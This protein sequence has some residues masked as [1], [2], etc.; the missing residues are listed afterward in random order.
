M[1][2]N[3]SNLTLE[4][5]VID[6][7]NAPCQNVTSFNCGVVNIIGNTSILGNARAFDM[8]W[9]PSEAYKDGTQITIDTTGTIKGTIYLDFYGA[10]DE[11][12]KSTLN[13]KNL[14]HEGTFEIQETY[15]GNPVYDLLVNQLTIEGGTYST[16]VSEYLGEEY[17][18]VKV[19]DSEYEVVTKQEV[20]KVEVPTVEVGENQVGVTVSEAASDTLK[21]IAASN[22]EVKKAIEEGKNV[23]VDIVVEP[24]A[25][26]MVVEEDKNLITT[27]EKDETPKT[28]VAS[29]VAIIASVLAIA[30]VSLVVVKTRKDIYKK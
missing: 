6:G 1:I 24:L 19:S 13:L 25:P 15:L 30:T 22:E 7:T 9:W 27:E 8:C 2:Q 29:Y 16:D 20:I 5:M 17:T 21:E 11:N 18:Q 26:E 4:D 3:Y 12:V 10:Y 28:G 23:S 14:K